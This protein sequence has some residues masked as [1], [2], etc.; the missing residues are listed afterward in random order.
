MVDH[1][2]ALERMNGVALSDFEIGLRNCQSSQEIRDYMSSHQRGTQVTA[3]RQ[4]D[5][6]VIYG[7]DAPV[8]APQAAPQAKPADDGQFRAIWI[9]PNGDLQVLE[10]ASQT[11]LDI[12]ER[13]MQTWTGA[14]KIR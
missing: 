14:R 13:S 4:A 2:T 3:T 9:K 1:R 6:S 10:A 5:G 11:G 12:L 7:G 8:T